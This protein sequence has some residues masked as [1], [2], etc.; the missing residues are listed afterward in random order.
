MEGWGT[1][2]EAEGSVQ[3]LTHPS[4]MEARLRILTAPD[5]RLPLTTLVLGLIGCA[6]GDAPTAPESTASPPSITTSSVPNGTVGEPYS[7]TLI[8]AGGDGSYEWSVNSGSLPSGLTL[9][10]GGEIA[11]TPTTAEA[12]SFTVRVLS[13]GQTASASLSIIIE[14]AGSPP[15]ITTS[16][17]PSGVV[18]QAFSQTLTVIGGDGSYEWSL[19]SGSLPAGLTL[20]AG[21]E[22]AGTPTTAETSSFTIQVESAGQTA[23]ASLSIV[24]APAGSPPSITTT[25]LPDGTVGEAYS[26]TLAATGGDG[27]YVWSLASGSL[28]AGL[29][30]SAG[31]QVTGT[32]TTAE[33]PS[34]TV[35]VASAGQIATASL[36][37]AVAAATPPPSITTSGLPSGT[38]G[39]AYSQTLTATGGDGSYVWSLSSGSLPSGL[40]LSPAGQI[41]GTPTTAETESFTVQVGSVGQTATASL[42]I[43]V[44]AA[45]APPSITTTSLPNGTVGQAYN[46]A[47]A[48]TG[49]DGSYVW[50]LSSG[51]LPAGLTLTPGGE[52][53]GTPTTA[54]APSFTVQV[55]SAGQTA[56]ASLSLVVAATPPAPV[57]SVEVIPSAT[58]LQVGQSVTLTAVLRDMSGNVLTERNVSWA[59]GNTAVANGIADDDQAVLLA[60]GLGGA[61]IYA[62]SEGITGIAVI[63]VNGP[64]TC[65]TV[66]GGEI[67]ADN[68]QYLGRL[69]N[70][71]DNQS[72]LNTF[73]PYGSEFSSTS[74]YNEFSQYGSPFSTLSAYNSLATT[75]PRLF[76]NGY[77]VAYVTKNTLRTPLVDPDALRSC[78]F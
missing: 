72:I 29:T 61:T 9:S 71:F 37:I 46:Q 50:T 74:M 75:P 68:S 26:H 23:T 69:T 32:P 49:G 4:I 25:S 13:A 45:G 11:G 65:S 44:A 6:G 21:G 34:F 1:S 56:T 16:S 54:G 5:W 12:S 7:L 22:I 76:V 30:L 58:A 10:V 39:Q 17:L 70:Q 2:I 33:A 14:A 52:I 31:G 59:S 62:T 41:M 35:Q 78:S 28:P 19:S 27:S 67:Y 48:A 66:A 18:G 60:V 8:A 15:S 43:A 36:S 42:S 40:T 24:V 55:A 53:A 20:S 47:L 63:V 51:S 77:A 3:E 57:A 38:V 73:G 64:L